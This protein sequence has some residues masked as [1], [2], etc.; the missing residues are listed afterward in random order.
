[1][2]YTPR[3]H[4]QRAA[5]ILMYHS[6]NFEDDIVSGHFIYLCNDCTQSRMTGRPSGIFQSRGRLLHPVVIPLSAFFLTP[7]LSSRGQ[8]KVIKLSA[9]LNKSIGSL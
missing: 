1:M 6:N 7:A 5:M 3:L 2:S 9:N 4:S 8:I